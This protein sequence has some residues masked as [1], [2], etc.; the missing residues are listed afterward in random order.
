MGCIDNRQEKIIEKEKNNNSTNEVQVNLAND[1]YNELEKAG[2]MAYY[3]NNMNLVNSYSR[4]KIIYIFN[5]DYYYMNESEKD[6]IEC[7]NA[8]IELKNCTI[9]FVNLNKI[10]GLEKSDN[11]YDF[12]NSIVYTAF[13][14]VYNLEN[15]QNISIT[16]SRDILLKHCSTEAEKNALSQYFKT[17]DTW[18]KCKD[19]LAYANVPMNNPDTN[20]TFII[21]N[22][23][24]M[25]KITGFKWK[26]TDLKQYFEFLDSSGF[27]SSNNL[28]NF[29]R[30]FRIAQ[31][32]VNNE[33]SDGEREIIYNAREFVIANFPKYDSNGIHKSDI[34]MY[35]NHCDNKV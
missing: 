13:T 15:E 27:N 2:E 30:Q 9:H 24:D 14:P 8:L 32:N 18:S 22:V 25:N 11:A 3:I 12:I 1:Y 19:S 23:E 28:L 6:K 35:F 7:E 17:I 21:D 26:Q 20:R 16:S 29:A 31:R 4:P 5:E 33:S 34:Q 10:E